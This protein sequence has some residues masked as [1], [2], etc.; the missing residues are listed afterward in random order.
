[1]KPRTLIC[2]LKIRLEKTGEGC[3]NLLEITSVLSVHIEYAIVWKKYNI[4]PQ[5]LA[6]KRWVDRW[7][8]DR[9]ASHFGWGRTAVVR[10]LGELKAN[11]ELIEDGVARSHVKS[12]KYRFMGS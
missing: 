11:P 6:S 10:K 7:T 5:E 2:N 3:A 9:I 1:M 12:R 4:D 8:V